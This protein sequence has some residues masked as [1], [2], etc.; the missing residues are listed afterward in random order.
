MSININENG[1]LKEV[2]GG[3]NRVYIIGFCINDNLTHM[4]GSGWT[5][6]SIWSG[7]ASITLP[8]EP[9]KIFLFGFANSGGSC[10]VG[11]AQGDS[12]YV[13]N[14]NIISGS[15]GTVRLDNNKITISSS[16]RFGL[17][18]FCFAIE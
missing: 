17:Q 8:F 5:S 1:T 12:Q 10:A 2:T 11:I 6:F 3:G 18:C 14:S 16:S 4:T 15:G 7:E 9:S 13:A